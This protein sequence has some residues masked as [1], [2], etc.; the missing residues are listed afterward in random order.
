VGRSGLKASLRA[1]VA[2]VLPPA[3]RDRAWKLGFHAPL[4]AYVAAL[5]D[6][7]RAGHGVTCELLGDG[8]DFDRLPPASRWRWGSVGAYLAWTRRRPAVLADSAAS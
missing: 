4:P 3:V 8:P 2:D 6:R 1:A 5:E 7:L